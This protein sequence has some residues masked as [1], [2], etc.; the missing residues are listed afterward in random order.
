VNS[1]SLYF[2]QLFDQLFQTC[3]NGL[4]GHGAYTQEA[5]DDLLNGFEAL[6]NQLSGD[7]ALMQGQALLCQIIAH[8]P[9][10]TPMMHRDL[11]W[12][13][14]GDCLHYLSDTELEQ[15]QQLEER[16]HATTACEDDADSGHYRDLRAKVFGMH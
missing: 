7:D 5:V 4:E 13:F 14:G 16:Y 10:I 9:D 12:Y 6:Q 2:H 8:F 11:L 3:K 15:Y 1:R